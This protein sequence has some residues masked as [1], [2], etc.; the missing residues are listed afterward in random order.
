MKLIKLFSFL[1]ILFF[2][3]QGNSQNIIGVKSELHQ[4]EYDNWVLTITPNQF[5]GY[6]TETTKQDGVYAVL[7]CYTVKGKEYQKYTDC[8][9]DFVNEGKN[10]IHIASSYK[11]RGEINIMRVQFFRRDKPRETYPA[12]D[13]F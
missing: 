4:N 12:K 1:T 9:Y 3:I 7:L 10:V 11:K 13:C 6:A 2:A 8:T 5:D